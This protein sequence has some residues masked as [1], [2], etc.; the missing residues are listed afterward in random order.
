MVERGAVVGRGP[1]PD[2][3]RTRGIIGQR[4]R[5]G[6]EAERDLAGPP[7]PVG[8]RLLVDVALPLDL[9]ELAAEGGDLGPPGRRSR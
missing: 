7:E 3:G 1:E 4:R 5:V 8:A 2:R 6:V 9:L